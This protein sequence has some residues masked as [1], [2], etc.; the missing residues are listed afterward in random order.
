M[1]FEEL[2]IDER[3]SKRFL[4]LMILRDIVPQILDKSV[5]IGRRIAL[6]RTW[7][8]FVCH[9]RESYC[10]EIERDWSK[11]GPSELE[12]VVRVLIRFASDVLRPVFME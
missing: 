12:K 10:I 11:W 6:A 1:S 9:L 3:F 4:A 8:D 2:N 5:F 7:L